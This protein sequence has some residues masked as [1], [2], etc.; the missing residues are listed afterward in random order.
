[1]GIGIRMDMGMGVGIG[2]GTGMGMSK[3]DR[4]GQGESR[5]CHA[6]QPALF[7]HSGCIQVCMLVC[8]DRQGKFGDH[9]RHD[10][11]CHTYS[12]LGT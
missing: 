8:D 11:H 7:L 6:S 5:R 9:H 3:G 12:R 10:H 1:M 4:N 2:I